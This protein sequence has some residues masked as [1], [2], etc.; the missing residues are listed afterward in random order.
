MGQIGNQRVPLL[1]A[2]VRAGKEESTDA[3]LSS[4]LL[5]QV[6]QQLQPDEIAI[7]DAGFKMAALQA[8]QIKQG[9]VRLAANS[10]A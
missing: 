10:T 8:A 7:F 5:E 9:V 1:K 3:S 6:G 2:L 4:T